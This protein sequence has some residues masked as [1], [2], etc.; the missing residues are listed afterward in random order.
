MQVSA[1]P[2]TKYTL[3]PNARHTLRPLGCTELLSQH[4]ISTLGRKEHSRNNVGLLRIP[5][6]EL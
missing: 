5:R 1:G 6:S 4:S 3:S 2:S